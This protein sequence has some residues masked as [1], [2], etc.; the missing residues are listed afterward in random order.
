MVKPYGKIYLTS[1]TGFFLPTE[2]R[3]PVSSSLQTLHPYIKF[4]TLTLFEL[5]TPFVSIPSGWFSTMVLLSLSVGFITVLPFCTVSFGKTKTKNRKD[6]HLKH[7]K[8]LTSIK[9]TSN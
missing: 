1:E 2:S 4:I 3:L 5:T 7:Y 6:R 8:K 9:L